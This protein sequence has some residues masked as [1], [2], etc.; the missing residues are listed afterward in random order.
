MLIL[1]WASLPK[2]P[3]VCARL[4]VVVTSLTAHPR[5]VPCAAEA[6]IRPSLFAAERASS[7]T[8]LPPFLALGPS[9]GVP[10]CLVM[11]KWSTGIE[12]NPEANEFSFGSGSPALKVTLFNRRELRMRIAP[13]RSRVSKWFPS[14]AL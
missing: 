8:Q 6:R 7:H 14:N 5:H 9:V 11:G 3:A 4:V 2:A 13:S 12:I 10:T 1:P